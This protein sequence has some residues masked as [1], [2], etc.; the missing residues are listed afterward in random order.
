M[1]PWLDLVAINTAKLAKVLIRLLR[2]GEGTAL[3]G[4]V[5]L[6]ISPKLLHYFSR[7]L[8]LSRKAHMQGLGARRACP[9]FVQTNEDEYNAADESFQAGSMVT[10]TNGK[11]TT[12]GILKEIYKAATKQDPISNEMGANLYYGIV[13]ELINSSNLGGK[14]KSN[15]YV[16][17]VDEA[18]FP[19]IS[20]ELVPSSI[21]VTNLFR[22]QLDRFGEIDTTQ[23]LIVKGIKHCV[24]STIVL[25]ADDTKV[26]EIKGLLNKQDF[27]FFSFRVESA[28]KISNLDSLTTEQ[29]E[30]DLVT[31]LIK[32]KIGS[33][34]IKLNYQGQSIELEL[35]LP[36]LYNVYNASAAAATAIVAGIDLETIKQGIANY[37]GNFGRAELKEFNGVQFTSFL[38]KNP[39]GATEVLK[40]LAQDPQAKYLIAINDNYADG[41]DVSW[42]WDA[43][44]ERLKTESTIVCSGSRAADMALRLKYA[45]INP[46]QI[47]IEN[48]LKKAVKLATSSKKA[49]E[50]LYLLP[51]YTAL[52]ELN[53]I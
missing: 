53:K 4:R 49:N 52:L 50:K 6:A 20:K 5:A 23:K 26:F 48:N 11:T 7:E 18:A 32:N 19:E 14:L 9:K 33:S 13:A 12:S 31:E 17:E 40:D 21:L 51:T 37:H 28:S 24:G 22:D 44:F 8:S 43:E 42:L 38:I 29:H 15:N 3:P 35:K 2:L 16:L 41:R 27:K 45:G 34:R 47:S 25:N 1:A 10:G 30:T 39:T 46:Q 36:G